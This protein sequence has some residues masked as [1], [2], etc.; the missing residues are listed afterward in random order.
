MTI[1]YFCDGVNFQP[2]N[3]RK[4]SNWLKFI[5]AQEGKKIDSLNC[6]FVSDEIM[7]EINRK[8]LN[9]NCYTDV[10]TFDNSVCESCVSG[11]MYISIDTVKINA[12]DYN[13][14]FF[15]ELLR[16]IS[17]GL[18]HLCGHKDKTPEEQRKM[19]ETE[20]KYLE[21]Y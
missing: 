16:V 6:V 3:K 13:V 19:R 17:H 11:E 5:A 1:R 18:L 4:I 9:H 21:K 20:N 8:F 14:N 15:N 2:D 10:V 12:E 7:I